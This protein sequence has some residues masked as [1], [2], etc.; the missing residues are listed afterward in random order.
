[1]RE[2]F[3]IYRG[4]NNIRIYPKSKLFTVML[5]EKK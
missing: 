1:M 4:A 3:G 5:L 2:L